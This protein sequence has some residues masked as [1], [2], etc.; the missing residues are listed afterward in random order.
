MAGG[1][2]TREA[3]NGIIDRVNDLCENPPEDT[4][5]EPLEP[6]EHVDPEHIWTTGDIDQVR[7]KLMEICKDNEFEEELDL[8]RQKTIDE[9]EEAI[10]AGWCDCE[11]DEECGPV[12]LR[13]TILYQG[14]DRNTYPVVPHYCSAPSDC[15]SWGRDSFDYY[16]PAT[17][18][19]SEW[20]EGIGGTIQVKRRITRPNGSLQSDQLCYTNT[21]VCDG[22]QKT[23]LPAAQYDGGVLR[24]SGMATEIP[25]C[26]RCSVYSGRSFLGWC[27][28]NKCWL[29][30][31]GCCNPAPTAPPYPCWTPPE[32]P[33]TLDEGYVRS[34]YGNPEESNG[35]TTTF[36]LRRIPIG[37][38]I[39][40]P[41][42]KC[43][44]DGIGWCDQG[45]C[46]GDPECEEDEE[47]V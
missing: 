39:P 45:D 19:L 41:C 43:C 9:I 30:I 6:L 33:C 17:E 24:Y 13:E 46:P 2:Y 26:L 1:P 20:D 3:W 12:S 8:W 31:I 38:S 23:P 34:Y 5:C 18:A 47:E 36:V 28:C 4:D 16:T 32:C 27:A 42:R 14:T 37:F 15:P 35:N 22:R 21:F 10:S 11:E 40:L 7:E 25:T 44:S 29:G